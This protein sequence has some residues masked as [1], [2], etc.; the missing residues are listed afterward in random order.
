[1][2]RRRTT[3]EKEEE[4]QQQEDQEDEE[5]DGKDLEFAGGRKMEREC[6]EGQGGNP[7]E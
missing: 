5:E 1:M 3:R 2:R 6:A 7:R 4:E